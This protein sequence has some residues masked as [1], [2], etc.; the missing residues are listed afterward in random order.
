MFTSFVSS[1]SLSVRGS[2][3]T[4]PSAFWYGAPGGTQ[5][6]LGKGGAAERW[7]VAYPIGIATRHG[8]KP[9]T[10]RAYKSRPPPGRRTGFAPCKINA[11]PKATT[12]SPQ[13]S[14]TTFHHRKVPPARQARSSSLAKGPAKGDHKSGP[15]KR[16]LPTPERLFLLFWFMPATH[17][18]GGA[19]SRTRR[20]HPRPC[21]RRW[22]KSPASDSS[23]GRTPSPCPYQ[24]QSTAAHP[25]C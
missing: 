13:K 6:P 19:A 17:L 20:P 25:P 12:N 10:T 7:R 3:G 22:E 2:W 5:G 11:P 1:R 24:S 14:F 21:G 15:Q 23:C 18:P 4:A 9:A 8:A 16:A